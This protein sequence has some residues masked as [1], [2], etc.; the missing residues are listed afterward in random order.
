MQV[1][2]LIKSCAAYA[3]RLTLCRETWLR[4]FPPEVDYT[5]LLGGTAPPAPAPHTYHTGT[6]DGY[7]SLPAKNLAGIL[8]ALTLPGWEWLI[9]CDDDT[10]LIPARLLAYLRTVPTDVNA[11]GCQDRHRY[12]DGTVRSVQGG[13]GYAIR[14]AAIERTIARHLSDE[15][16]IPDIGA[17]D[18]EISRAVYEAGYPWLA[19]PYFRLRGDPADYYIA[20]HCLPYTRM[21][22]LHAYYLTHHD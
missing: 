4:D 21:R 8:H 19:S 13:S 11:I 12:A 5:V 3:P 22:D 6:D 15:H 7:P 14:R 2:I 1:H 16:R 9:S 10:Y 18:L 20:Q 17:D